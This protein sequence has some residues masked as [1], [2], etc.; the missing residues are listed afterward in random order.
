VRVIKHWNGLPRETVETPSLD[1]FKILLDMV[2]GNW[3]SVALP[4][5][6][7]VDKMTSRGLFQ[8]Q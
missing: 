7:G 5:R 2:L 4:D 1:I 3:L 8:P 6:G